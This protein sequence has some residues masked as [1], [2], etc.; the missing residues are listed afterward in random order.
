M[1]NDWYR[2]IFRRAFEHDSHLK[3]LLVSR[4]QLNASLDL[5]KHDAQVVADAPEP[6]EKAP[7]FVGRVQA[8]GREA[9]MAP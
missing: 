7:G 5:D 6:S 9:A 8:E 2:L 1:M 3:E 4:A